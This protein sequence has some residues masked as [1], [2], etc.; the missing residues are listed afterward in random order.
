MP[1]KY[2]LAPE[3]TPSGPPRNVAQA[4]VRAADAWAAGETFSP[5]F[6]LAVVRHKLIDAIRALGGG[7][8]GREGRALGR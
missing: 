2:K 4:Y 8:Q 7:G 3:G 5:D 6:E 1:D